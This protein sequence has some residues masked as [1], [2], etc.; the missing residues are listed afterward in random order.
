MLRRLFSLA[1]L[2]LF[3]VTGFFFAGAFLVL[4]MGLAALFIVALLI[5]MIWRR[6][7]GRPLWTVRMLRPQHFQHTAQAGARSAPDSGSGRVIDG[8][9]DA[10]D[11][12][13]NDNER[14]PDERR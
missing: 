9:V 3:V 13:V 14:L 11:N 12:S 7:T 5:S 2:V 4:I 10:P 1:I 6:L 8:V